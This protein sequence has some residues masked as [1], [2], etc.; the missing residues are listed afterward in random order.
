MTAGGRPGLLE[1]SCDCSGIP[2]A[3]AAGTEEMSMRVALGVCGVAA[4]GNLQA[5]LDSAQP[6]DVILLQA[7]ATF[8]GNY[9]LPVKSGATMITVQTDIAATGAL[10]AG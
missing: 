2:L 3:M 4:G 10:A 6:G 8:T 5:A 1:V 7:G 9:I